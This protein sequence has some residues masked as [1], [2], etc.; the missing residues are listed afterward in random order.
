MNYA[1][2]LERDVM[3]RVRTIYFLSL[4]TSHRAIQAVLLTA[5]VFF[6]AVIVSVPNV[7]HNMSR[8][9]GF[10]DYLNY[11]YAAFMHTS[12]YVE[13]SLILAVSIA[14]WLAVDLWRELKPQRLL[15]ILSGRAGRL[16]AM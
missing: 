14:I 3:T 16:A 1:T 11:L 9:P 15:K 7:I 4:I 8:L 10:M 2:Q 6:T 12:F 13:S 5:S